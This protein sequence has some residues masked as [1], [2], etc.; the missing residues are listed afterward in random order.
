MLVLKHHIE[1]SYVLDK[2]EMYEIKALMDYE[3]YSHRDEWEQARLISYLIAQVN[4]KKKLK[5]EDILQFYWDN[6]KEPE[7]EITKRDLERLKNKAQEYLKTINGGLRN[8]SEGSG[9]PEQ[10]S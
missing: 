4:S 7:T 2:M 5:Q 1:P 6:E 8:K 9:Q 3:Y 10:N